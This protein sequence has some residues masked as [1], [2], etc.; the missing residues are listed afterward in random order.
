MQMNNRR[1]LIIFS[2]ILSLGSA[3]RFY[4]LDHESLEN[5]ELA[6]W[7]EIHHENLGSMIEGLRYGMSPPL[8]HILLYFVIKHF[9]DSEVALRIPSAVSG[10]LS[11]IVI[12]F[13]GRHLYSEKEGLMAAGLTALLWCPV[14]YSQEARVYSLLL[15]FTLLSTYLWITMTPLPVRST[16]QTFTLVGGL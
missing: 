2:L 1:V 13:L 12:F 7:V 11:I 3:L 4:G 16:I 6:S 5:D 9:G 15:L 8:Y 10:V 14:Y